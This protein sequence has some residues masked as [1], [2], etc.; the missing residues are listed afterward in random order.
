MSVP[1]VRPGRT[2]ALVEELDLMPTIIAE[3]TGK[4]AARCPPDV[5]ASRGVDTRVEG[6]IL[7]ELL[8]ATNGQ[9]GPHQARH[10]PALPAPPQSSFT[11]AF[12]QFPRPEHNQPMTEP[13]KM[14][15]SV[16]SATYRYTLW[17]GWDRTAAAANFSDVYGIEL[18]NH[19]A[20]PVPVSYDMEST[21]I[22]GEP[23]T[24][25][26]IAQLHAAL[27]D[28]HQSQGGPTLPPTP[29]PPVPPA[30]PAQFTEHADAYCSTAGTNATKVSDKDGVALTDC[31][32]AC[33]TDAACLCF[34]HLN[35]HKQTCRTYHR[36]VAVRK[37]SKG[38]DCYTR[39]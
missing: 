33:A 9:F 31:Q 13:D 24:G 10:F 21:N 1:G 39:N 38:W 5:H 23:G 32:A 14:G 28:R 16:R 29:A 25:D 19:S 34:E 27:L 6:R 36:Q 22:A 35:S 15:L 2:N 30:P 26:I 7:S 17:V 18:Y 37:S 20:A 11:L 4:A 8:P 12:S 3:A